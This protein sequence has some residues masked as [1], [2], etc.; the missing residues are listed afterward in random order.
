MGTGV[1][2]LDEID[3]LMASTDP[4]LINLLYDTGHLVFAGYDP[5]QVAQKYADRIKHIHLKDV[6]ENI[7]REC[8]T[9]DLSF[10]EAVKRGIFTVPGDGM[11]DFEPIFRIFEN[12]GYSGWMVV[13][14]EQDPEMANPFR[15]A[16]KARKYIQEKTGL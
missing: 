1:Q 2:T 8:K 10:L 14:A 16:L 5:V 12:S 13:E 15:Y 6:R 4:E 7:L 9:E 3:A 11:I